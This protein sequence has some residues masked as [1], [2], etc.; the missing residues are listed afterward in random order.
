[1]PS[2]V[3]K[4][5]AVP[6]IDQNQSRQF[7][8]NSN[9]FLSDL[10]RQDYAQAWPFAKTETVKQLRLATL[11]NQNDD[12]GSTHIYSDLIWVQPGLSFPSPLGS[13]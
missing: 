3:F 9:V 10:H 5:Y 13:W 7:H 4:L 6:I 12:P 8:T 11:A 2:L 1:M